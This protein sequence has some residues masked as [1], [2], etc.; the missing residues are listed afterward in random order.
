MIF[1]EARTCINLV[2]LSLL[3]V[4]LFFLTAS[5]PNLIFCYVLVCFFHHML[6]LCSFAI[7]AVV[8]GHSYELCEA[9]TLSFSFALK[10]FFSGAHISPFSFYIRVF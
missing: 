4:H 9:A 1:L 7:C 5:L 10:I 8:F 2:S 3:Q 6:L